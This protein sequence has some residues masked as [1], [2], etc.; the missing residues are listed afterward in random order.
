[1]IGKQ[2]G[3]RYCFYIYLTYH[4]FRTHEIVNVNTNR[5]A[6]KPLALLVHHELM[7]E[8][9]RGDKF[10][11]QPSI[12]QGK[13]DHD[14]SS[15]CLFVIVSNTNRQMPIKAF[16]CNKKGTGTQEQ[17]LFTRLDCFGIHE[18]VVDSDIYLK[19]GNLRY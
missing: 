2:E 3:Q 4:Y 6:L 11:K 19:Y 15:M 10:L 8:E 16:Q 5:C 9:R 7:I 17:I 12:S 13:K 14:S 18:L 1:M